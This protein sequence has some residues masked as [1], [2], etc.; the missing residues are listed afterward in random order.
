MTLKGDLIVPQKEG[1]EYVFSLRIKP[2][3]LKEIEDVA[4]K[5]N[6]TKSDFIRKAISDA[7]SFSEMFKRN[8]T[9]LVSPKMTEFALNLMNDSEIERFALMSIQNGQDILKTYLKYRS[10]STIV[11]QYLDSKKTMITGLLKY[12][13]YSILA[14]TGQEWFQ[15]IQFTWDENNVIIAGI[16][17][18]GE[19]FSKFILLY[20]T[21]FFRIFGCTECEN[22]RILK[23]DRLKIGFTGDMKEFDVKLLM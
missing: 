17:K 6:M 8:Q 22:I 10:H 14:P 23:E 2:S 4:R 3:L 7:M 9:F 16:H 21:Y 1:N 18:L 19:K 20:F 13:I 11:K 5:E 12:I 15:R